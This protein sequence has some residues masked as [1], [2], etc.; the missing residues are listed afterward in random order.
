MSIFL[1]FTEKGL[2]IAKNTTQLLYTDNSTLLGSLTKSEVMN[3]FK[4]VPIIQILYRPGLTIL[5]IAIKSKMF[6]SD[7]TY[8]Y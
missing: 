3:A 4:N 2:E 8:Y 6:H 5:D 7:G 1:L